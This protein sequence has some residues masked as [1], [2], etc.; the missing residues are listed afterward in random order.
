M[1]VL[2]TL[3]C[4]FCAAYL[5]WASAAGFVSEPAPPATNDSLLIIHSRVAEVGCV[6]CVGGV[7][8]RRDVCLYTCMDAGM[9]D[10]RANI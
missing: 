7:S 5:G 1:V 2:R 9:Y 6:G 3:R 8:I 4:S 10:T